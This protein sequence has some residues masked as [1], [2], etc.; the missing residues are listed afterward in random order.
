MAGTTAASRAAV[1]ERARPFVDFLYPLDSIGGWNKIYGKRGFYQ[2]QC[3][4]PDAEAPKGLQR[5]LEEISASRAASFLAV[6]KTLAARARACSPSRR[7]ASPWRSISRRSGTLELL[8]RLERITLDHGGRIYLAKDQA[9]SAE[10]FRAMYPSLPEFEAVLARVDPEGRF[11]SDQSRRLHIKPQDPARMTDTW[12]VLGASSA[13]AR[14]FAREAVAAGDGVVLAGRDRADLDLTAAGP[15]DPRAPRRSRS[16]TSTRSPSRAMRTPSRAPRRSRRGTLA[17]FVAYGFMPSQEELNAD[18]AL[19]KRVVDVNYTSVVNLLQVAAPVFEAQ[20]QGR[21]VVLG[22]VAG[23]RGRMKNYVYGSAKAGVHEFLS[24]FRGRMFKS[25][26]S[27]TT[28]KPGVIDTAMTWGLPGV[29]GGAPP[30]LVARETS[31]RRQ[32]RPRGALHARHL[33]YHHGGGARDPRAHLQ[34]PGILGSA[35]IMNAVRI[36]IAGCSGRMGQMLVREVLATD[37]AVLAGGSERADSA[38]VGKDLGTLVGGDRARR[39]RSRRSGGAVRGRGRRDRLHRARRQR[40]AR[41]TSRPRP[42]ARW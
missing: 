33:A 14:A 11:A 23:D 41:A 21:I 32:A 36:G 30:E 10:G 37:G 17:L 24:G 29:R 20:K 9:L 2:F 8:G 34:A 27:V 13:I 19:A 39:R 28:V 16:S 18:P 7:A 25:G 26:V 40:R 1:R 31:A 35:A 6:L 15:R 42:G 22:S 12:L 3:V 5:L 38:A 4:L